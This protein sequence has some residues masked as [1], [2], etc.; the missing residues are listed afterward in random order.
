MA[1]WEHLW[2]LSCRHLDI[3]PYPLYRLPW[4][5][6]GKESVCQCKRRGFNPWIKKIPWRGNWQPTPVF[7]PGKP[8]GQRSMAVYSPWGCKDLIT[9]QLP[10][11]LYLSVFLKYFIN[12]KKTSERDSLARKVSGRWGSGKPLSSGIFVIYSQTES[13]IGTVFLAWPLHV[14]TA[15]GRE[16]LLMSL[17]R[18]QTHFPQKPLENSSFSPI[19]PA[20]RRPGVDWLRPVFQ[21]QSQASYFW[22]YFWIMGTWKEL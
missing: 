22:G 20:R 12:T 2:N 5:L 4:W 1:K 15:K 13:E 7:L 18:V 3:L 11:H 6:S 14:T 10:Q 9:K 16:R 21:S 19:G 8:H 17:L